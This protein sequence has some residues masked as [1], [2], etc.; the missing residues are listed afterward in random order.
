[1]SSSFSDPPA[2]SRQRKRRCRSLR[3]ILR[4]RSGVSS[5]EWALVAAAFMLT[6]I[7]LFDLVRYVVVVQSVATVMMQAG[8]ACLL[9][10]CPESS[11]TWTNLPAFVI[12]MLDPSQFNVTALANGNATTCPGGSP[13]VSSSSNGVNVIQVTVQYPY[14]AMAPWMSALNGTVCENAIYFY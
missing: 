12:P 8:R 5:L 4:E 2:L 6:I 1:M 14:T 13:Q 11:S 10:D 3:T 9:G 7:S